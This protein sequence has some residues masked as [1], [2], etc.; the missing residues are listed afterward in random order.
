MN[1]TT[2]FR[3]LSAPAS[4]NL[5]RTVSSCPNLQSLGLASSHSLSPK[6]DTPQISFGTTMNIPHNFQSSPP[7]M[8]GGD[9]GSS[10][11]IRINATTT[12]NNPLQSIREQMMRNQH[13]YAH[14]Y[15]KQ[16]PL[17][18]P[19]PPFGNDGGESGTTNDSNP[20]VR[21][22]RDTLRSL[23]Y[24]SAASRSDFSAMSSQ[25]TPPPSVG[26]GHASRGRR[27][28]GRLLPP[29]GP[30]PRTPGRPHAAL[31]ADADWNRTPPLF[32]P[33]TNA[34]ETAS[35]EV[36]KKLRTETGSIPTTSL[37]S[38]SSSS[39]MRM[40][41]RFESGHVL[42]TLASALALS[43][44]PVPTAGT[45]KTAAKKAVQPP[46]PPPLHVG[47]GTAERATVSEGKNDMSTRPNKVKR[48]AS[49]I[50]DFPN[51]DFV[52][53]GISSTP[54]TPESKL[55]RSSASPR[56]VRSGTERRRPRRRMSA[57]S[58]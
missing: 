51:I 33:R 26:N 52:S 6:H 13:K 45:R 34:L 36:T 58:A 47:V 49:D 30:T 23:L 12:H 31:A 48:A 19:P 39:S 7:S 21:Q 22:P 24:S 5:R 28:G 9:G 38:S 40:R 14:P 17:L 41:P 4:F 16:E 10:S 55:S 25:T 56:I 2:H 57:P 27:V 3:N 42:Q 29:P 1:R 20:H 53:L 37:S 50:V 15:T 35:Q 46:G 43:A 44:P 32:F 8:S 11:N 18:P 54:S